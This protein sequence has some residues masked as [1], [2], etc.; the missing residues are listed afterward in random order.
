MRKI[1][2]FRVRY[3][4]SP[5]GFRFQERLETLRPRNLGTGEMQMS[6]FASQRLYLSSLGTTLTSSWLDAMG[7]LS[8]WIAKESS[9]WFG[10][11]STSRLRTK[12]QIK[13]RPQAAISTSKANANNSI[14]TSILRRLKASRWVCG[15]LQLDVPL[16]TSRFWSSVWKVWSRQLRNWTRVCLLTKSVSNTCWITVVNQTR[17]PRTFLMLKW[18]MKIYLIKTSLIRRTR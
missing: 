4:F 1:F 14:T 13:F 7:Y 16:T 18:T 15:K 17:T 12:C 2:M 6:L 11:V 5:A 8:A 10:T 3:E 9:M